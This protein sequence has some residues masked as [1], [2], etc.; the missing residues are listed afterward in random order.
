MASPSV[1]VYPHF[2]AAGR[3]E[4][5]VQHHRLVKRFAAAEVR[6]LCHGSERQT[7]VAVWAVFHSGILSFSP[8]GLTGLAPRLR[9]VFPRAGARVRACAC[10]S[11]ASSRGGCFHL[12]FSAVSGVCP[13]CPVSCGG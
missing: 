12:G 4:A 3:F 13:V 6:T 9:F 5:A 2:V 7:S 10:Q 8:F 1:L 11:T